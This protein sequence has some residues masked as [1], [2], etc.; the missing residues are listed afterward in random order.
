MVKNA[1]N[2]MLLSCT[3]HDLSVGCACV[4]TDSCYIRLKRTIRVCVYVCAFICVRGL[5]AVSKVERVTSAERWR[6]KKLRCRV[7]VKC[8]GDHR[9][10]RT[11]QVT[12]D[13]HSGPAAVSRVRHLRVFSPSRYKHISKEKPSGRRGQFFFHFLPLFIRAG[14]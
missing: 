4:I 13:A 9:V 3:H 5:E 11:V 8:P 10:K 7:K 12:R 1:R 6:P 14:K 2:N